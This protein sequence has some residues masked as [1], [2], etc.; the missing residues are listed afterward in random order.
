MVHVP[1]RDLKPHEGRIKDFLIREGYCEGKLTPECVEE[2]IDDI[3]DEYESKC[4][5]PDQNHECERLFDLL[6]S[7]EKVKV[8][9]EKY[10]NE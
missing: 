2:A 8:F 10:A 4:E 3:N 5:S 6:A 1:T 7:L 9:L